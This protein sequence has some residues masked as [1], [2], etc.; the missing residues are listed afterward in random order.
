MNEI[1]DDKKVFIDSFLE[2]S[3]I[4]R[5]ATADR[6]GKPHVVPVWYA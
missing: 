4:A 5:L 1:S 6:E 2:G 3:H